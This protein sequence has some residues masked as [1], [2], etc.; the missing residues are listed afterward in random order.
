MSN[1]QEGSPIRWNTFNFKDDKGT[2]LG[3]Q[4]LQTLLQKLQEAQDNPS[5]SLSVHNLLATR[6]LELR[7]NT[8]LPSRLREPLP[9]DVQADG[10]SHVPVPV[11]N[12]NLPPR[13]LMEEAMEEPHQE[14]AATMSYQRGRH[15][16]RSPSPKRG[17]KRKRLQKQTSKRRR[18]PS[19]DSMSST[20]SG[21]NP[22]GRF[23]KERKNAPSPPSDPSSSSDDTPSDS[24]EDS[25]SSSSMEERRRKKRSHDCHKQKA[26][27]IMKKKKKRRHP[28]FREGS[29]NVSFLPMM[30]LM[31]P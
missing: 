20:R 14:P 21:R 17:R 18:S 29:K 11:E 25:T 22:R 15:H 6:D 27:A 1:S 10:T 24:N 19:I 3:M 7:Y 16:D 30:V 5:L 12:T 8:R 13:M 23:Y 31:V 26:K 2:A 9:Q 4:N 28:K